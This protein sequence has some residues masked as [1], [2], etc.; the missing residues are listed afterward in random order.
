MNESKEATHRRFYEAFHNWFM[1]EDSSC[2]FWSECDAPE[3]LATIAVEIYDQHRTTA[4]AVIG[5]ARQYREAETDG[6]PRM[7]RGKDL[8]DLANTLD[9]ALAAYDARNNQG[10]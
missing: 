10:S 4:D 2:D 9:E 1:S 8:Q 6:T 3:V 5:A 7:W